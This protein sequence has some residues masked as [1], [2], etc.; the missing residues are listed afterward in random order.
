MKRLMKL[1][2][3]FSK[4]VFGYVSLSLIILIIFYYLYFNGQIQ[5]EYVVYD[6]KVNA[7]L[8]LS[9]QD[10]LLLDVRKPFND[11]YI[12]AALL[13]TDIVTIRMSDST[14]TFETEI[15]G[16]FVDAESELQETEYQGFYNQYNEY[17]KLN[18]PEL[19]SNSV[20]AVYTLTIETHSKNGI[21]LLGSA[22]GEVAYRITKQ[23]N[24]ND[25]IFCFVILVIIIGTIV[26]AKISYGENNVVKIYTFIAVLLGMIYF[27]LFPP[28]CTNDSTPHIIAIYERVNTLL[29]RA[30]WN[31]V[32]GNSHITYYA[33]G[34]GYIIQEVLWD[35]E[36]KYASPNTKMYDESL[37]V[38]FMRMANNEKIKS[39][40]H[41]DLSSVSSIVYLPYI[42]VMFFGRLMN[43]NFMF[44]LILMKIAGFL[45][46]L[47]MIRLAVRI[48][49]FG[50]EAL[51]IFSLTPMMLQSMVSIGYDIFCIGG[52]FIAFAFVFR[53]YN[54]DYRPTHKDALI[55]MAIFLFLLPNKGGVYSACFLFILTGLAVMKKYRKY[56]WAIIGSVIGICSIVVILNYETI[57]KLLDA[58]LE[59]RHSRAELFINPIET[60]KF[61][62]VSIITDVDKVIQG[63]FGG[64]L[65]WNEGIVPWFIIILN[66]LLFLMVCFYVKENKTFPFKEEKIISSLVVVLFTIG[67][68]FIFLS[69]TKLSYASIAGIQ[70]RYFVPLIPLIICM[71]KNRVCILEC[72]VN[73]LFVIAW[74]LSILNVMFIM[75]VYLRR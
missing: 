73:L 65:G 49:P 15:S 41:S 36:Q 24:A 48:M 32:D 25:I 46:Y 28:G 30:D 43:F 8:K 47:F 69:E 68:Y 61:I 62:I 7:I 11:I 31:N 40:I 4:R 75:T 70:G 29:G 3:V 26:I 38:P 63:M 1:E 54:V 71:T 55:A 17:Y 57:V 67:I 44:T 13:C 72:K 34:D 16:N 50:K 39:G 74:F 64:R 9:S 14:N 18:L 58:G 60:I 5:H 52:S 22:D 33:E 12:P 35:S 20:P 27:V 45:C 59:E 21:V 6:S 19:Q 2:T 23:S 51:A 42:V 37:Y 10:T 56:I 66:I 53:L